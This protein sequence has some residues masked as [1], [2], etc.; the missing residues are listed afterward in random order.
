M[1]SSSKNLQSNTIP[2]YYSSEI[3]KYPLLT[4]KEEKKLFIAIS[5]QRKLISKLTDEKEIEKE[6]IILD[7]LVDKV[8]KSNLGLVIS[9]ANKYHNSSNELNDLI[10]EGN[11]GLLVAI[12]KFDP[13]QGFKYGTYATYWIRQKIQRYLIVD[14]ALVLPYNKQEKKAQISNIILTYTKRNGKK[15]TD[16]E[17]IKIYNEKYPNKIN[18][19]ELETIKQLPTTTTSIDQ[20][21][22]N[23]DDGKIIPRHLREQ[24]LIDEEIAKQID[25]DM[26]DKIADEKLTDRQKYV[27]YRRY[28]LNDEE[29]MNYQN[30]ADDLNLSRTR[31]R[32]IEKN[33]LDT[34]SRNKTLK[35]LYLDYCKGGKH[36]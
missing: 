20:D 4:K 31:V 26:V 35:L 11:V 32:Q 33:G 34:L 25:M 29:I 17:I 23:L 5:K 10:Q 30:I 15:P 27:I 2:N 16:E 24:N 8:V 14:R 22:G 1:K 19:K 7:K 9:I 3:D 13:N 36:D 12:N 28:G 18:Q 6:K 21:F